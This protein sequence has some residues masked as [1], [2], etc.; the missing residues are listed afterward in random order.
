VRA[1]GEGSNQFASAADPEFVEHC[2]E[3]FLQ[4]VGRDLEL[5]DNVGGGSSLQNQRNNATLSSRE[6]VGRQD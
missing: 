3:M 6:A 1:D 4:G 2:V 5:F